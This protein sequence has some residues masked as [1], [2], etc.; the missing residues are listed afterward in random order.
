M[1]DAPA[2]NRLTRVLRQRFW[3]P[4]G[5]VFAI[6]ITGIAAASMLTPA[7]AG[8]DAL[9]EAPAATATSAAPI[10]AGDASALA[11]F[12]LAP[13]L[14]AADGAAYADIA[15]WVAIAALPT[16]TPP[17]PPTP[18]PPAPPVRA[19]SAPKLPTPKP[20]VA[21]PVAPPAPAPARPAPASSGLPQL[22]TSAMTAIEQA[23]FN[24]TNSR[25]VANGL[26][27]L[28]A[29]QSLVG[30]ARVRSQEMARLDYFSHD[31]PIY[32]SGAAFTLMDRYGV[33]YG[34]AGENLAKNNYPL[35]QCEGVAADALWNSPPHRENIL[36]A[37][38]TQ[39]GV[40]FAE[41]ASGMVYFTIV[42]DGPA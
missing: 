33:P 23:L 29:N 15:K 21:P 1:P 42:F 10:P 8:H 24:D 17:P 3:L 22:D 28:A 4:I 39:M 16:P 34:W 40:G 20:P 31:S 26:A 36:G 35:D 13:G 32:G 25:R 14:P 9:T 37:H 2:D 6:A 19:A 41:D 27:P 12:G 38:Y 7:A 5:G 18:V 30:I 11:S